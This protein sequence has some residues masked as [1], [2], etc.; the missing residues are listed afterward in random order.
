MYICDVFDVVLL[1][2][3]T[4]VAVSFIYRCLFIHHSGCGDGARPSA[5]KVITGKSNICVS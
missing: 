4:I 3:T 1:I 5:D 2:I